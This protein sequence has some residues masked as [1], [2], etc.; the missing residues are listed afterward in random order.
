MRLGLIIPF[1]L[2][3]PLISAEP[4][5]E[6]KAPRPM[7][8]A[9]CAPRAWL[10]LEVSKPDATLAAQVPALPK[11]MGFLVKSVD[12]VG[13]AQAAGIL[14]LDL[15]WKLGDQM[16]VNESQLAA[17]LR[18]SH[19]GQEVV[20][21]GFRGGQPLE[22]KLTLGEAP[23]G[24]RPFPGALAEALILPGGMGQCGGPMRV[25]NVAE[26]SASF[27][28]GQERAVVRRDGQIY[29][30]KIDGPE[31]KVLFEGELAKEEKLDKLPEN[32]R[33]R[34][35]VLCRT[36][37]RALDSGMTSQRQ[38]RPRVVPAVAQEP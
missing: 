4:T 12:D 24:K 25:V 30:V 23:I 2:A 7:L 36:L 35:H 20:F 38:P 10:G 9:V 13:P 32:W 1:F 18:L 29:Q 33:Q 37:D 21:S 27:S 5:A 8:T 34:V 15:L 22:V 14:E 31:D 26:K 19:P 3:Q 11:G 17:L 16:L 28:V 6:I